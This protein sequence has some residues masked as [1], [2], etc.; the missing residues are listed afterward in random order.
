MRTEKIRGKKE[1][2]FISEQ[3]AINKTKLK[4]DRDTCYLAR[5]V[6]SGKVFVASAVGDL[7]DRDAVFVS[8]KGE[9][10]DAITARKL[11]KK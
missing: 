2:E 11:L 1:A 9:L 10:D 6:E 7:A 5:L 3:T 4:S 8:E